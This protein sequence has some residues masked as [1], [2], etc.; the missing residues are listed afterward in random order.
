MAEQT[1]DIE[2][3]V[4]TLDSRSRTYTVGSQLTVKEFKEH[5]APSVGIPVDKQRLIYQGR[6]LQDERTLADYNVGGKVIHLVERAPPPP[7]QAGSGSGG[8]SADSGPSSSSQGTSQVPHDRNANS[9]VMLGTFN[10]PVNIMDPQQIQ[11]TVQQMVSGM[12]E[13][14]RVTTSS[15]TNGSVNVHIDMDQPIQS[16]PRLR[17]VLAENLLRDVNNVINR[18]EGR[19]SDSSQT[20]TTSAAA[21]PPPPSSS[22]TT[23]TPS[24]SAQPMDTSPPPTTPP[25]PSTSS[26][27]SE[28]PTPQPGPHHPSP[29]ELAEMLSELRRVEERLQPFIQR[30]HTILETAT[31]AEY[32]NNT[33]REE[34]QRTLF[35]ICECFRLLGNALVAL[36]DLRLNLMTPV[37]RHLH[38]MRPFSHYTSPV[39]LPGAVHHHIP[40]QMNLGATVTVAGNST[41]GQTPPTQPA[42]QSE[43]AGQGQTSP[44]QTTPS[45]QQAGQGQAGPR[46][47]RISHQAVPV[48]MMQMNTDGPSGNSAAGT[49]QMPGQP[50]AVPPDFMR[51]L[52]QQV[53]QYATAFATA[54][55]GQPVPPQPTPPNTTPTSSATTTGPNT[56]TT[57]PTAPPPPSHAGPQQPLARVVFTRPPFG[58]NMPPPAFG[59]RGTTINVRAAMP[60]QQ[61]GQAF[62]PA[63]LNQM[64][65]GL[66]GQLLLPG[67]L[68]GQAVTSNSSTSTFTTTSSSSSSSSETSS[69]STSFTFAAT[70]PTPPPAASAASTQN[71]AGTTSGEPQDL[72]P[73][74]RQLLGSLLGMAG[75]AGGGPTGAPSITVTTSGVPAFFQG[76]TEF[77]QQASQPIFSPP[78]HPSGTAPAPGSEPNTAGNP[79]TAA[80]A[81]AESLNPELFTG[82]VRGVL[83]T[84][85]GSLGQAQNDTESIAQFMQRLSQA[86]NIFI[87]PEDPTGFFGELLMLVCQTFTMSDLVML[88]HGQ[89]QPLSRIQ[90]QLS[91]FFTQNYL[92]GREPTDENITAAAD[93]L[94]NEL[95]EY[96]TESFRESSVTVLDGVDVTQTNMS[97]FR[98]QLTQIATHILRCTD[99]TFGPRLLQMCNQALFECLALNMHCL[100]GDQRALTAVINHRIRRMS[101]D[102][103]PSLVNWMTSMMTMRLQVILE[104]IPVSLEQIQS[105]IVYTQMDPT[106]G[107]STQGAERAQSETIGDTLSPAAATTAEEAMSVSRDMASSSR[108]MR[109]LPTDLG[110]SGGAAPLGGDM[111]AAG[112]EGGNEDSEGESETWAA[113]V[114]PEWVPII[115]CDMMTQ[116]KMKAQPPLSDA[117]L[118]GM[119]AK[120]RKTGQG[121][122]SLLSLSDAVSQAARTAGVR[123]ITSVEQLQGDLE[124]E[125]VKE[126]YSEQVKADVKKR[127]REDPDFSPQKFPNAHRAFSSDP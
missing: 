39:T 52:M 125:E 109:A 82:I 102:I 22:S 124:T 108:E 31:T 122:G 71:Q 25:P 21:P 104:H 94:V 16:E 17:L 55:T 59:P 14:A 105:Y 79:P 115:R 64:I 83:S 54:P 12:G 81:G 18:M 88:L 41:E 27:E 96:I 97:F 46:V 13:N 117:Y 60:A 86:T 43:Q 111:A 36:S 7:S 95:E 68:A 121:S 99:E 93:T 116:R 107:S 118:H 103:S 120:R 74:L 26:A 32:N 61:P 98:Q 113:V 119:P 89:H 100:R 5:I 84:M 42:S 6:V 1:S 123:P 3:T 45:N 114:P 101:S 23:S 126:A 69:S 127:L 48:V 34:D 90:P 58:S 85:M 77:M 28:G 51:N 57:T 15:G 37:P 8:T 49:P 87:S 20:E 11:M 112:A 67:Q 24:P 106:S 72:A 110:A 47:I 80:T 66:V 4:K 50:G 33:E 92:N 56:P 30:G 70:G 9:Y 53:S 73:D 91:Q 78:P 76:M 10:L 63:A 40:V 19:T 35:Q 29:A 44:S 75:G 2:V 38:V 62:N 65:S